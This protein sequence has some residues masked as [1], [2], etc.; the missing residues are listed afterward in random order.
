MTP[1]PRAGLAIAGAGAVA[2]VAG[3]GVGLLLAAIVLMAT[4]TDI[5]FARRT[6]DVDR[7]LPRFIPRG[8]D[9]EIHIDT[10]RDGRTIDLRQPLPPDLESPDQEG[11]GTISGRLTAHRRGRHTIPPLATRTVGPMGFGAVVRDVGAPHDV[12]VFPDVVTAKNLSRAVA[13]GTFSTRG[14]R[15]G[16]RLGIGTEFESVRDYAPEDDVRQINWPVTA[17]LGRPMSNQY[18]V[19]QDRS[20][21]C[22]I[23]TGRLMAA[24][25]GRMTRLDAAVDAAAAIG[26][27]ADELGD[28]SGLLAFSSTIRRRFD[29][30]RRAGSLMVNA[31]FDLE[32]T[33]DESDYLR[34]FHAVGGM[35][36]SLVIVFTDLFE[37]AAARPLI[38]AVPVLTRRHTVM[39]ASSDDDDLRAALAAEP[40]GVYA[41]YRAAAAVDAIDA[42][43]RVA[44]RLRHL[45]ASVVIAG[46]GQ[47]P[48]AAVAAYLNAK[49]RARL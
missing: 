30:K 36:R 6:P 8:L 9:A 49:R 20:V 24:P 12:I 47:L 26:Y 23:D 42:R 43:D 15:S 5:V 11:R 3:I 41:V 48:E 31:V 28:R 16:L 4:V 37:P 2:L 25:L 22:V 35:K 33:A 27:T 46:R 14:R 45:G 40:D 19:D 32:P 44:H 21:I 39:V 18:R 1:T 7:R 34:A 10:R 38:D 29:P 17:R 13:T